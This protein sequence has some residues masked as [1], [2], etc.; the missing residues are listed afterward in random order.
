MGAAHADDDSP[1]SS[2]NGRRLESNGHGRHGPGSGRGAGPRS[3]APT[4]KPS[5]GRRLLVLAAAA[6]LLALI[7]GRMELRAS[8]PVSVLPEENADIRAAVE[9][10]VE[11]I[12]VDEG[13]RVRAGDPIARLSSQTLET[14][15]HSTEA[16]VRELRAVVQG[17]VKGPTNAEIQVARATLSRTEAAAEYARTQLSRVSQLFQIGA[18]PRAQL[19][20]ARAAVSTAEGVRVESQRRLNVLLAGTR[21]D[22]IEAARARLERLESQENDLS[23]QFAK[24]NVVSPVAGIVATP[25]RELKAMKRQLIGSGGLI[26]KVYDFE[27][28]AAQIRVPEKSI[29]DV[30]PGQPVELRT[31]ANPNVTFHGRVTSIAVAADA[32]P[33]T[34]TASPLPITHAGGDRVFV[35]TS[36]IDNRSLFL[37]PGMTGQA[38]VLCGQR[39]V[40]NLL[41]RQLVRTLNVEVWSWW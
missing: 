37:R 24:L 11:E 1:D 5:P 10:I 8:G 35:V 21:P 30:R 25:S 39:S 14:N 36:L 22:E 13:D 20:D 41:T 38:K 2:T 9:G 15:L 26:A 17:L 12:F 23:Q 7:F 34:E 3:H 16:E 28:V 19:D 29:G 27:T 4:K 33:V 32:A 40:I 31:R 18:V 6:L